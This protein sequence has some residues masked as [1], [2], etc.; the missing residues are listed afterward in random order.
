MNKTIRWVLWSP[1][2]AITALAG[3]FVLLLVTSTAI[4]GLSADANPGQGDTAPT[5][6][7]PATEARLGPAAATDKARAFIAAW[8]DT[9]QAPSAW[10]AGMRPHLDP[11]LVA[12]MYGVD[13]T[14]VPTADVTD[15][16]AAGVY[17]SSAL[18]NVTLTD[19]TTLAV[20]LTTAAEGGWLVTDL[21]L[22]DRGH[23]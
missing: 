6:A 8:Q 9:D 2:N 22:A 1:R 18:V 17:P 20:S 12:R 13:Q 19:G 23:E 10:V 7:Q 21:T 5:G 4:G 15:V 11:L 14:Q 16:T 3:G